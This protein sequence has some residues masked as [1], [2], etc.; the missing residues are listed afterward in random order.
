[1]MK[2]KQ[3]WVYDGISFDSREEMTYYKH[4][5]TVP[6]IKSIHRQIS[7]TILPKVVYYVK[8]KLKTK[9]KLVE[10]VASSKRIYTCDFIYELDGQIYIVDVKSY[11]THSM[12]YWG[13]TKDLM[14]R[15]LCEHNNKR[16]SNIKFREV[17]VTFV[18]KR[19]GGGYT[20][21]YIDKL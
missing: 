14:I 1:M 11:Y 7:F 13:F 12:R 5:L 20:L 15:K 10:R 19:N 17:I 18:P 21:K 4:L 6:G 3:E 16:K 8:K 2:A 9:E